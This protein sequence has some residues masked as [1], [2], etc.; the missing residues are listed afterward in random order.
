M[1]VLDHPPHIQSPSPPIHTNRQGEAERGRGR[2]RQRQRPPSALPAEQH[3]RVRT[4]TTPSRCT[5]RC[6]LS[7]TRACSTMH[8]VSTGRCSTVPGVST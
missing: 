1:S 6:L 7:G 2:E 4:A 5:A 3:T 8:Y